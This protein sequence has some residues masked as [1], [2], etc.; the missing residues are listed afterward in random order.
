[1]LIIGAFYIKRL[2]SPSA[3]G[4]AQILFSLCLALSKFITFSLHFTKPEGG[5]I[6]CNVFH[7]CSILLLQPHVMSH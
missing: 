3:F 6:Q 1:M 5:F 2:L 7:C 4:F